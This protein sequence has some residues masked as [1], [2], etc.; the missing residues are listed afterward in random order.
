MEI[1]QNPPTSS[2]S[3]PRK[4][5]GRNSDIRKEQNRIA[6]RAYREKRRQKLALLDEILKSDSHNDSMSSVSNETEYGS[7]TP[8]SEPRAIESSCRTRHSSN[9]PTPYH[10]PAV[11]TLTLVPE[12]IPT[13]P[14][15][16]ISR[17]ME[18]YVSYGAKDYG[19]EA[20]KF[21]G[22]ADYASDPRIPVVR[23]T[24]DYVPPLPSATPMP[25]TPMFPFNGAVMGD[26][27]GAY[28]L[29]DDSV[30]GFPDMGEYDSNMI[31]ALQTISRLSDSQQQQII[32]YLLKKNNIAQLTMTDHASSSTYG[33]YHVPAP[34][35]L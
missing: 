31:N 33:D 7:T 28:P 2:D 10:V 29:P 8:A 5:K 15:N 24:P 23:I 27:F 6:S 1:S 30:P 18:T 20:E 12:G 22:H 32:A 26:S 16:G 4:R 11:L 14:S 21:A 9:S 17:E 19:Q 34:G 25:S 3:Q 35:C 13:L